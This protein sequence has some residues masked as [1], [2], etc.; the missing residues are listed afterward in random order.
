M[1][2]S[3]PHIDGG[4]TRTVA[5]DGLSVPRSGKLGKAVSSAFQNA[6]VPA[7][8]LLPRVGKANKTEHRGA[9]RTSLLLPALLGQ[10][11]RR[12]GC[13]PQTCLHLPLSFFFSQ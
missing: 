7:K 5:R 13:F 1:C 12:R 10:S 6:T 8:S 3:D 2:K 4:H 11:A 9:G